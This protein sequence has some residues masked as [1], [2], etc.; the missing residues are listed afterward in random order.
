MLEPTAFPSTMTK[1]L[2][3]LI[4]STT[5]L[6]AAPPDTNY[7][8]SKV[9]DYTLPALLVGADGSKVT[10]PE[11]WSGSRRA[12]LM[13]LF[14]GHWFGRTPELKGSPK[15]EVIS[16]KEEA[17]GG[18]AT[19]K[20]IRVTH[21]SYPAWKGMEIMLHMPNGVAT[22]VPVFV[23]VS[24]HGNHCVTTDT[25][26]PLSATW[27]RDNPKAKDTVVDNRYTEA[28]RGS[29]SSRWPLAMI[30]KRGFAVASY[31]YGDI[32]PDHPEG[33]K[34]GLRGAVSQTFAPDEWGAIGAWAWGLSRVLDAC[35]QEPGI[36]AKR[37]A[38]FGHSRLGKT[39]LWA[40]AQDE[41]FT[42]V[43]SNNSG[44]GGAAIARRKFGERTAGMVKNF[45]HWFCDAHD[46]YADN[47]AALPVDAH[48]LIALAAPRLCYIASA[49][50]DTWADPKGEFLSGYH[51]SEV[52]ALYGK[53]G[54]VAKEW[55]TVNTPVGDCIGYHMRT[56]EHDVRD[57][58]W[59]RYMDFAERHWK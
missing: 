47:E 38:S 33:W 16:T 26:I 57:Y 23:G 8:E 51:A 17:L 20:L 19:R 12:E 39:S 53:Q 34:D 50:Q 31:Y 10:T 37:A 54:V 25:D 4:L 2:P 22:A 15:F 56:G 5:M 13:K 11:Q 43:I 3:L 21:P 40:G 28:S 52:W 1:L 24:F 55:P 45:P 46:Q 44:E 58:D 35:E 14:E 18:I 49:E 9:G 41:R 59:E 32:E 36:D 6:E 48:T 42:M 29:E 7:D 30:V 27:A